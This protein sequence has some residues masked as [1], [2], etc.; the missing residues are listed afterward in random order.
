ML[1][2]SAV[3]EQL[4][5]P[6]AEDKLENPTTVIVYLGIVIDSIKQEICFLLERYNELSSLLEQ[7]QRCKKCIEWELLSLTGKL[8]LLLRL[9]G[10][11]S[12][13]FVD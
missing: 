3:F 9:L 5:I 6:V 1:Q 4:G 2:L 10:L 8:A 7:W 12:Y 11:A 13:F